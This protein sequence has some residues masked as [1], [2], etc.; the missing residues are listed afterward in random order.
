MP[1]VACRKELTQDGIS[2]GHTVT[3]LLHSVR[4]GEEEKCKGHQ[5]ESPFNK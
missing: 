1:L 5:L 3:I 2:L 4:S